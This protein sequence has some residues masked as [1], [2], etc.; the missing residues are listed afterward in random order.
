[1]V[2]HPPLVR[3][4]GI[5]NHI[6]VLLA[7]AMPATTYGAPTTFQFEANIVEL[8]VSPGVD[9]QL[10]FSL[11]SGDRIRSTFTIDADL[12][13][14]GSN[15][16]LLPIQ[17]KLTTVELAAS[18]YLAA[19]D[20]AFP[21]QPPA[22]TPFSSVSLATY[23]PTDA[24]P[25]GSEVLIPGSSNVIWTFSALSIGEGGALNAPSSLANASKWNELG[26]LRELNIDFTTL[27]HAR[28][29][30]GV[31]SRVRATIG[32]VTQIPEPAT[33]LIVGGGL[34][35]FL[36]RMSLFRRRRVARPAILS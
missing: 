2:N 24:F 15:P 6:V 20:A 22:P 14:T 29:N 18:R 10:P 8:V 17:F 5:V 35:I 28:A 3:R 30:D 4:N 13:T 27:E 34:S 11:A 36:A 19:I 33:W 12:L 9:F 7:I 23:D 31:A 1:M 21:I 32:T 16:Q 25:P 26:L